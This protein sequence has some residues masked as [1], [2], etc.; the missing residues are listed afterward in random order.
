MSRSCW[1]TREESVLKKKKKKPHISTLVVISKWPGATHLIHPGLRLL[2]PFVA[3]D[4]GSRRWPCSPSTGGTLGRSWSRPRSK[5]E[6][7]KSD[8]NHLCLFITPLPKQVKRTYLLKGVLRCLKAHI[9]HS[10]ITTLASHS[11]PRCNYFLHYLLM[12][13]Y[14]TLPLPCCLFKQQAI[15]II[16]PKLDQWP[17]WSQAWLAGQSLWSH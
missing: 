12:G 6:S 1:T 5:T 14:Q 17:N 15:Q 10:W 4:I 8:W 3:W 9:F 16:Y 7:I 11:F 2:Q 13:P